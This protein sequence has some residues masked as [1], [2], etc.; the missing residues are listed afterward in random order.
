MFCHCTDTI[1]DVLLIWDGPISRLYEFLIA[2]NNSNLYVKFT[3]DYDLVRISFLD[4]YICKD[5]EGRL[6]CSLYRKHSAVNTLLHATS[7]HPQPFINSIQ[8]NLNGIALVN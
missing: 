5:Q 4:N 8:Y 2:L 6:S 7:A 1:D 3:M